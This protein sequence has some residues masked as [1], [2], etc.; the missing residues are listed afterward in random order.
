MRFHPAVLSPR[1]GRLVELL[2]VL[3][4]TLDVLRIRLDPVT[5]CV[6]AGVHGYVMR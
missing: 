4:L 3:L 2:L 5:L 1:F 6:A